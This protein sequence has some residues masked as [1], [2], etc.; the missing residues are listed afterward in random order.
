MTRAFLLFCLIGL[1]QPL[2]CL[3]ASDGNTAFSKKQEHQKIAKYLI[4]EM[5][6]VIKHET[7][8]KIYLNVENLEFSNEGIVVKGENDKCIFLPVICSNSSGMYI[9][10]NYAVPAIP[11]ECVKCGNRYMY[12]FIKRS[13]PKCGSTSRRTLT[14]RRW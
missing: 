14:P 9:R 8:Q 4:S 7:A 1:L 5:P 3:T 11:S 2:S 6:E 12:S 10:R 13:C